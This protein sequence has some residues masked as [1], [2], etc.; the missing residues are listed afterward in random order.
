MNFGEKL[1]TTVTNLSFLAFDL[2]LVSL[3]KISLLKTHNHKRGRLLGTWNGRQNFDL[4]FVGMAT[5]MLKIKSNGTV[6]NYETVPLDFTFST[7]LSIPTNGAF[8]ILTS[9]PGNF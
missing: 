5:L 3:R 9:I 8:K 1:G 2:F 4:T 6:S 7:K